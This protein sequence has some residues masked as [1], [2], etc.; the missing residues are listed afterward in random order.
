MGA[1][2]GIHSGASN[3]FPNQRFLLPPGP[4]LFFNQQPVCSYPCCGGHVFRHSLFI[5]AANPPRIKINQLLCLKK[6]LF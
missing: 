3:N 6:P 4:G 1:L 2:L 5:A